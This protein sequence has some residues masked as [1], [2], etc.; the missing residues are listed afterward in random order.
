MTD[1]SFFRWASGGLLAGA[2]FTSGFYRARADRLGG[3]LPAKPEGLP[4]TPIRVAIGLLVWG[5]LLLPI[6]APSVVRWM[7]VELPRGV[8]FLGLALTAGA[9]PILWWTLA[10]IGT[11]ISQSISTRANASLITHGPYRFVRHPLY[12]AGFLALLGLGLSLQSIPLLVGVVAL[13]AWLPRRAS[14]EEDNLTASYGDSYRE[15]AKRTG[16]F[17]PRFRGPTR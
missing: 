11:N 17:I 14:R 4:A 10:T 13:V 6:V 7:T 5:A 16:R 2:I 8:R 3:K 9:W 12:S 1:D 15:Y